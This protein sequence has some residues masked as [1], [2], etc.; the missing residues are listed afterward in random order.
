MAGRLAVTVEHDNIRISDARFIQSFD[1][2]AQ[3]RRIRRQ[4]GTTDRADLN[5]DDVALLEERPPGVL[6]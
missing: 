4:F 2:G 5:A 1:N 3:Y 6:P